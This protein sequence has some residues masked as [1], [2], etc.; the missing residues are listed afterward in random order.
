MTARFAPPAT[1]LPPYNPDGRCPKCGHDQVTTTHYADGCNDKRCST[2]D[3][4]HLRRMCQRCKHQWAEAIADPATAAPSKP[5]ASVADPA[6][7]QMPPEPP[8]GTVYSNGADA[9][10]RVD[11]DI[12]ED[13]RWYTTDQPDYQRWED[14]AE[15]VTGPGWRRYVPDPAAHA[16]E[17]P[18]HIKNEA[19]ITIARIEESDS[20]EDRLFVDMEYQHLR[21]DRVRELASAL[22]AWAA[23]EVQQP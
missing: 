9:I 10:V 4:E 1:V 19:G 22:W 16:P 20:Y 7:E 12:D 14:I 8:N 23:R 2:C 17:L 15:T 3:R 11:S 18:L 5:M 13:G 6:T 21:R